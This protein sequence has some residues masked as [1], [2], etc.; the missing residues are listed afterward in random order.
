MVG[1]GEISKAKFKEWAGKS[2]SYSSL[3]ERK[4]KHG[5]AKRGRPPLPN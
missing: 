5:K 1:R 4:K 2:A 3:P